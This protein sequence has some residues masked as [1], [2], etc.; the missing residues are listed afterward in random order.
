MF[1]IFNREPWGKRIK[2]DKKWTLSSRIFSCAW[3]YNNWAPNPI[4]SMECPGPPQKKWLNIFMGLPGGVK[5][6]L[7]G[8]GFKDV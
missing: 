6:T 2:F 3:P 5:K 4:I 7:L 8:D 1:A